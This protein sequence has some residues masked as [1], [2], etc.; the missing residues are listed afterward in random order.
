MCDCFAAE[1]LQKVERWVDGE[2]CLFYL[3]NGD[4]PRELA[5][6]SKIARPGDLLVMH[7]WGTEYPASAVD[8]AVKEND[9]VP[10]QPDFW[11]RFKNKQMAFRKA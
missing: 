1:T 6:Y 8:E 5:A 10:F 7:D 4:K 11:K 9:L 3:D 2:R